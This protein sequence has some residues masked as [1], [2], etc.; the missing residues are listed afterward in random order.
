M[1]IIV[2][3][4]SSKKSAYIKTSCRCGGNE[5]MI[6]SLKLMDLMKELYSNKTWKKFYK[7]KLNKFFVQYENGSPIERIT[8]YDVTDF[9]NT[10]KSNTP[11]QL[12]Y[13]NALNAFYSFAHE[14][15]KVSNIMQ[16]VKKPAVKRK[17]RKYI[18]DKDLVDIKKFILNSDNKLNDRLLLGLLLYTGLPRR[19]IFDLQNSNIKEGT[20]PKYSI[21]IIDE[22]GEHRI[23]ISRS[24]ENL[25]DTYL[26]QTKN[27]SPNSKV[28][29]YSQDTYIS[30]RV[31]KLTKEIT[32]S[33]YSPQIIGDTFIKLAL[34]CDPD[35]Y[36]IARTVLKSVGTIEKHL[37]NN[38]DEILLEKQIKLV[39]S[40]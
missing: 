25:I 13:Y 10:F 21:W 8:S 17:V 30:T 23:P 33:S 2:I 37:T 18:N 36:S 16:D 20:N 9:L 14:Q 26:D 19:Y 5:K 28:F 31:A 24:I 7:P 39:N 6:N 27:A 35:V 3:R 32:G 1:R 34:I 12:N 4:G 29:S 11:I 15:E 40:I 22:N 38:I